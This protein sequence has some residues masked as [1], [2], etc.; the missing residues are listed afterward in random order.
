[1]VDQLTAV[2]KNVMEYIA[3]HIKTTGMPP[4]LREIAGHFG[5][6]AVGTAQ[7][8]VSALRKKGFLQTPEKGKARQNVPSLEYLPQLPSS[9]QPSK[10]APPIKSGF[11]PAREL[12][13]LEVPLLGL[14][15]AGNPSEAIESAESFVTFPSPGT[16]V[17]RKKHYAL[18]VEGFSM[19]YAG[20]LPGDYLLVE[21]SDTANNGDIVVA[22]LRGNE[23]TV[24]R[25]ALKGS[26]LY[27]EAV[28]KSGI[29][30]SGAGLDDL[31]PAILVPEN[32]DFEAIPFGQE[33]SDRIVGLV[34][35][36]F[37]RN[38]N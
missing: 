16:G 10:V 3:S 14:V 20:F 18:A 12:A 1:M 23:V 30:K 25:F 8:I 22:A 24:K 36:L 13:V 9:S 38:V 2:Q 28:Q 21:S 11:D 37:R 5:W 15:Q 34:R 29:R 6:K 7:D 19:L 35:S 31:P 26:L 33:D 27:K 32:P 17:R 4:T